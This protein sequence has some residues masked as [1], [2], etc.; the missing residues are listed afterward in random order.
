MNNNFLVALVA[1]L[2]LTQVAAHT[3]IEQLSVIRNGTFV[4][5]YGYPRSYLSRTDPGF[6]GGASSQWLLPP[7]QSNRIRVDDSDL[8]CRP[9]QR[10]QVQSEKW[11]RLNIAP[12]DYAA[13]KYAENGHVTLPDNQKGKPEKGGTVYVFGTLEPKEDETLS[14]V[15]KWTS[16]GSGGDK[17]GKLL[18]ANNFDDGRCY[19]INSGEISLQ[20]QKEFPDPNPGQPTSVNEQYCETDVKIPEDIE[21][22]KTYTLYWVW[23]WPTAKGGVDPTYPDGKDEY[24][25]TCSDVEITNP[26]SLQSFVAGSVQQQYKL[27]QQDPQTKAVSTYTDRTAVSVDP[28]RAG[29]SSGSSS[30]TTPGS[31]PNSSSASAVTPTQGGASDPLETVYVTITASPTTKS[32][33]TEMVTITGPV[34]LVTQYLTS[35]ILA[36]RGASPRSNLQVGPERRSVHHRRGLGFMGSEQSV[37]SHGSGEP[38]E[39]DDNLAVR[40][41]SSGAAPSAMAVPSTMMIMMMLFTIA[42]AFA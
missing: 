18:T 7:L 34:P 1:A 33:V 5:N 26:N 12:G 37:E 22:G 32:M 20:R 36:A 29:S 3:W 38:T 4:G 17:R 14:N 19:Q 28:D 11:P 9:E 16:D 30:A 31:T 35:T 15:L 40:Q 8:L 39:S 6:N 10:K 42:Y 25:T 21:T 41:A 23:D 2:L 27:E 13:M 24:Y